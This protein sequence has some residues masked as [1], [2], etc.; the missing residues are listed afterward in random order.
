MERALKRAGGGQYGSIIHF[1]HGFHPAARLTGAS[2]I[3]DI[4]VKG[5]NAVGLGIPWW[6]PGGG[7]NH[8]D[9][10]VLMQSMWIDGQQI[11]SEG[12]IVGPAAL[13]RLEHELEPAYR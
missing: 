7:E 3:E 1:S 2:F 8:P 11:V 6:L 12:A 4:R 10:V 13:A 9:A 5:N